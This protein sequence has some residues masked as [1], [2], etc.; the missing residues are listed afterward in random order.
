MAP[1]TTSTIGYPR[2]GPNR[3]VKKALES[4]WSGKSTK[5]ALLATAREIDEAAWKTQADAGINLVALDGTLYDQVA[6]F[7]L[8]YLGLVPPRFKVRYS[9]PGLLDL[10]CHH[11]HMSLLSLASINRIFLVWMLTSPLPEV[12]LGLGLWT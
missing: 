5:E 3:E 8:T 9:P 10:I 2:I 12:L 7:A 11:N 6:D 1:T 4:Y